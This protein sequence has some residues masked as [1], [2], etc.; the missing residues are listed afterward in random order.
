M[1]LKRFVTMRSV[2]DNHQYFI[3][4]NSPKD[5]FNVAGEIHRLGEH[6]YQQIRLRSSPAS[7]KLYKW[8]KLEDIIN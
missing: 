6:R 1:S 4:C 3:E 5:A 7:K 2:T 8:I